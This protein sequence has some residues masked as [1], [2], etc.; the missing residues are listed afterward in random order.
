MQVYRLAKCLSLKA[1]YQ[2][3]HHAAD[4]LTLKDDAFA[5]ALKGKFADE[6]HTSV[7][8]DP[9]KVVNSINS[10]RAWHVHNVIFQLNWDLAENAHD[11]PG[12]PQ[13]SFFYKWPVSG[14]NVVDTHN[15]G[16]QIAMNF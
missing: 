12:A 11:A 6:A 16:G 8:T 13:L 1:A 14:K 5:S 2:Y 4:S 10:L 7:I 3:I 9:N 15:V